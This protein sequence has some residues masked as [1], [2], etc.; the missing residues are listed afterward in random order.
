M[1]GPTA[2]YKRYIAA[3]DRFFKPAII[4]FF[5]REFPSL[6]G[7]VTRQ[8]IA[9]EIIS[10]F[11][12]QN[13]QS[14]RLKHGQIFWNA[15]DKRTR[16]D[17]PKRKYVP[18]I[19]TLVTS[20]EVEKIA[21]GKAFAKVRQDSIARVIREA[22]QQ[23]GILSMRDIALI[24]SISDCQASILRK[25]YEQEHSVI[26][27]HAG[28]LQDMGS[29][30]T[31]KVQIVYKVIVEKKDPTQAAY[32]TNHTQRAVDRYLNDFHRVNTLYKDN[33]DIDFIH[34]VTNIAKYVVIQY[35]DIIEK[36]IEKHEN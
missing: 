16:A 10:I 21:N 20:E 33:R 25:Q 13:P 9:D 28:S 19:L 26:L 27:P 7:P 3:K 34:S 24:F 22:Y 8:N 14:E 15:L 12:K 6:F 35:I 11:E 23:G 4:N 32:E 36:Y 17:S 2:R 1:I 31:H 5:T 18:V 29:C 30:V